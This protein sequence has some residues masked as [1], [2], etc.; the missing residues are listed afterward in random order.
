[1]YT[2][3]FVTWHVSKTCTQESVEFLL[4]HQG[5][6]QVKLT[7]LLKRREEHSDSWPSTVAALTCAEVWWFSLHAFLPSVQKSAQYKWK[8][9]F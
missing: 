6:P 9:R 4:F 3:R 7:F 8:V 1:M 2:S 5:Y